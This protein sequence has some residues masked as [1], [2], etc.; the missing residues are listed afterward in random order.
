[1]D[2]LHFSSLLQMKEM[3]KRFALI[4]YHTDQLSA[5]LVI[6]MVSEKILETWIEA[7]THNKDFFSNSVNLTFNNK[8]L[9]AKNFSLP[10]DCFVFLK[11]LKEGANKFLI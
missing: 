3:N 6:H 5:V 8:L 11:T 1:M 7:K 2:K 4:A 9:I 10:N